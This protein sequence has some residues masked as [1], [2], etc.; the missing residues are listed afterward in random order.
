[1]GA[2]TIYRWDDTDAPVL[3][4]TAG[5]AWNMLKKCLIEGYGSKAAAGWSMLFENV[6]Q[7]I[8]VMRNNAVTGTGTI[9]QV[10]DDAISTYTYGGKG[11]MVSGYESMS[12]ELTGSGQWGYVAAQG[13]MKSNWNTDLY[14]IPWVIIADDRAFYFFAA[15]NKTDGQIVATDKYI[16]AFFVGDA[17]PYF[18][19]DEH[20]AL[21]IVGSY[22]GD[23]YLGTLGNFN[24]SAATGHHAWRDIDG[25]NLGMGCSQMTSGPAYTNLGTVASHLPYPYHGNLITMKP[26]V[27]NGVAYSIRGELPGFRGICHTHPLSNFETVSIEGAD[28]MIMNVEVTTNL[29]GQSAIDITETFRP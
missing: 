7:D 16:H 1:M 18:P 24:A 9:Y 17:V 6:N 2:P 14:P 4:G 12:D 19:E 28:H 22:S 5:S 15:Y 23:G 26:V 13:L 3:N 20:F 27:N 29:Y 10:I 8:G 21:V 11:F 25:G